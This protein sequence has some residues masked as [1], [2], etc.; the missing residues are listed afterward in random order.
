MINSHDPHRPY[1][2]SNGEKKLFKNRDIPQPS[3]I[4]TDKEVDVPGFLPDLPG[5]K[6]ELCQYYNSVKRL[7]DTVGAILKA[8]KDSGEDKNTVIMFLSDNGMSQPFCKT[9]CYYH[10][11]R[12]P[13]IVYAPFL[14]ESGIKDNEHF[15]SGIDFFPTVLDIAGL[16]IP[17]GLDGSSFKSILEGEKQPW[18]DFV[19]TEFLSTSGKKAFPMRSI[20]NERFVYIF[21]PWAI[22]SLMF[23]NESIGGIAFQ[24]MK[25]YSYLDSSINERVNFNLYRDIEEFYDLKKDSDALCNL[26]NHP[27]YQKDIEKMRMQMF[28]HMKKIGDP[29][30]RVFIKRNDKEKL[31]TYLVEIQNYVLERHKNNKK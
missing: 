19:Y 26:I 20:Q 10:S 29:L 17:K 14:Y 9:N 2:G 28:D 18:K 6:T 7:D 30:Q 3:Y 11:T 23:K 13:W 4:Y 21:N 24:E 12:T 25:K 27:A 31:R 16:K 1:Y 5:V 8:L 15:I 22:D